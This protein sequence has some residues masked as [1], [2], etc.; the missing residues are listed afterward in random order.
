[1][2]EECVVFVSSDS[3]Y[4]GSTT[5][6]AQATNSALKQSRLQYIYMSYKGLLSSFFLVFKLLHIAGPICEFFRSP[7]A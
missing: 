2:T 4:F 6:Y 5:Q 7:C 3:D 1:M